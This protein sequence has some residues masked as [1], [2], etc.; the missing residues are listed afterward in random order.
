ML[1]ALSAHRAS[2]RWAATSDCIREVGTTG[3]VTSIARL[4]AVVAGDST[5]SD[6]GK[7]GRQLLGRGSTV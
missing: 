4:V 7:H 1:S 3:F 2:W 6:A 5:I